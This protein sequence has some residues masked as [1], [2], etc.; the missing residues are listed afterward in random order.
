MGSEN[1]GPK[2]PNGGPYAKVR[3][4]EQPVH[5]VELAPFLLSKHEMTQGQW[6]RLAGTNPSKY[7]PGS[8]EGADESGLPPHDLSHPVGGLSRLEATRVLRRAGL[9]LPTEAQWEYAA[10]AGTRTPW[11]WGDSID[12]LVGDVMAANFADQAYCVNVN[13][14]AEQ[15][16][17][18]HDGYATTAPVGTL[19]PN[20]L[21]LHH[22]LGNLWEWVREDFCNGYDGTLTR[23]GEAEREGG[24]MVGSGILRGASFMSKPGNDDKTY[25]AHRLVNTADSGTPLYGVRP[26]IPW[27]SSSKP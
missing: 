9:V 4:E 19:R 13:G 6:L 21:G 26:A 10:R 7:H 2:V 5:I 14:E 25:A 8:M 17:P 3:R 15:F 11:W 24:Q 16:L 18:W 12:G 20:P 22:T 23:G 1:G 27:P